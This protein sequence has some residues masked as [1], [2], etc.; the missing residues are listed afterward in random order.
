MRSWA[1]AREDQEVDLSQ[2]PSP[3]SEYADQMLADLVV[4]AWDL[5]K[6]AKGRA[7]A[8]ERLHREHDLDELAAENLLAYLEDEREATGA[9]LPGF[10]EAD[11]ERRMGLLTEALTS[12]RR[13]IPT[14]S[15]FL[16]V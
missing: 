3:A 8:A 7:R 5:A 16:Y 4:H 11:E 15:R 12:G 9:L 2:G 6:G 10:A 1:M 14:S 13:G